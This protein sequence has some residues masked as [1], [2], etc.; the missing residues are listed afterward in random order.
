MKIYKNITTKEKKEE[1]R[2]LKEEIKNRI[3]RLKR[4]VNQ[5]ENKM[6]V[7]EKYLEININNN[8]R[9]EKKI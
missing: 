1:I 5:L 4:E 3:E 6:R 7:L 9:A 2:L 8:W